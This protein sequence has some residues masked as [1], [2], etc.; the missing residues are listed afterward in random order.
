MLPKDLLF[1]GSQHKGSKPREEDRNS[2]D[3][4][5]PEGGSRISP[6][7]LTQACMENSRHSFSMSRYSVRNVWP[8]TFCT[9]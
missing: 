6:V 7:S 9:T 3:C 8:I 4:L 5:N 2:K 1:L